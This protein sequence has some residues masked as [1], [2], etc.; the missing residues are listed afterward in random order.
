MRRYIAKIVTLV[1]LLY[2]AAVPVAQAALQRVGPVN[3]TFGYPTW[4]QD[5]TGLTLE[6]CSP[7]NAAEL[8]GG[9]CLI[10]PPVAPATLPVAPEVFPNQFFN[11]HFYSNAT[12]G[13]R[14]LTGAL[15]T[16]GVEGA[17]A[18]GPVIPGDQ[19][20]FGRIRVVIPSLP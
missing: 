14:H 5:K 15:L 12:A 1:S 8:S 13:G 6:F 16:I 2:I 17:F 4:Y 19:I 10:L 9:W 7:T 11:E 3:P 20:T 18:A